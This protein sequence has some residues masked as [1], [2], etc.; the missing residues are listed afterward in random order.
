MIYLFL[1]LD[2]FEKSYSNKGE[3]R[4]KKLTEF[5]RKAS[6]YTAEQLLL[7]QKA[8]SY[9]YSPS[10]FYRLVTFPSPE[11]ANLHLQ[12][13]QADHTFHSEEFPEDRLDNLWQ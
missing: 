5:F 7:D 6:R 3:Y 11:Q 1:K 2:L 10:I 8:D 9:H 4:L 13:G 12:Q